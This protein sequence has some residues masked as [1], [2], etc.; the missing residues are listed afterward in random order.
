MKASDFSLPDEHGSMHSL[1][2]Y[3]GK[4]LVIYFYPK[5]DTPGCTKEACSFRDSTSLLSQMDVNVIGISKDSVD[6]HKKFHDK[7]KL[8]FTLLS[9]ESL[10]V[11]KKYDAW[12]KKKF[13]GKEYEGVLRV[14]YIVD[15]SGEIRK[16]YESVNPLNHTPEII[17]DL[18]VLTS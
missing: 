16:K 3:K 7:Y 4:W 2:D 5:D 8:N 11:I 1:S 15:G 17:K 14:T 13:L 18:Q 10:S 6:S 9:D 12:G